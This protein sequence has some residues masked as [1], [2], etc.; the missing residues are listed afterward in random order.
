MDIK[1]AT[2]IMRMTLRLADCE[3]TH[4]YWFHFSS[5]NVNVDQ[6][7]GN[8]NNAAW[9]LYVLCHFS[10]ENLTPMLQIWVHGNET[11]NQKAWKWMFMLSKGQSICSVLVYSTLM[12]WRN[13]IMSL[14]FTN[15]YYGDLNLTIHLYTTQLH[16]CNSRLKPKMLVPWL[17]LAAQNSRSRP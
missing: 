13:T 17:F 6:P 12:G 4:V 11:K 15:V 16:N 1:R 7:N 10:L 5:M 8:P 2:T 3:H 14:I 9:T